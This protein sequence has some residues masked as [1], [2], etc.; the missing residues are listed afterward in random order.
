MTLLLFVHLLA[1]TAWVGGGFAS[2]TVAIAGRSE[3]PAGQ[4]I[5]ARLQWALARWL[6]LPGALFTVLSGLLLTFRLM[7]GSAMGSSWMVL[8]QVT[9]L[10]GALIALFVTVPAAA[11]LARLDATGPHAGYADRLRGRLRLAGSVSGTLG[12]IAMLA[13]ALYRYGR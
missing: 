7:H 5:V 6:I 9:G 1:F 4:G 13:G 10:L 12:L 3:G 11:R 2:M 8:M